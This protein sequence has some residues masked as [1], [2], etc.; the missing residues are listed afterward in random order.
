MKIYILKIY[1]IRLKDTK[2][3]EKDLKIHNIKY[4]QNLTMEQ[5]I[6]FVED[7]IPGSTKFTGISEGEYNAYFYNLTDAIYAAEYNLG[8][9][10]E[11]GAF[12]YITI[13][14]VESGVV[15]SESH[16]SEF[17]VYKFNGNDGYEEVINKEDEIYKYLA[18]ASNAT[19]II[20]HT[21]YIKLNLTKEEEE[22]TK[23]F[24]SSLKENMDKKDYQKV[25][26]LIDAKEE[27]VSK[28][29]DNFF[30]EMNTSFQQ[31]DASINKFFDIF[32]GK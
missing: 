31:V 32:N 8:D 3:L 4:N 13:T 11:S 2:I 26:Q 29:F 25:K 1:D 15:Y 16:P 10:N 22:S 7:I 24:V 19:H 17:Y 6:E 30:N 23:Q 5:Y 12:N 20:N 28:K 21:P 18:I 27:N 14:C 9:I